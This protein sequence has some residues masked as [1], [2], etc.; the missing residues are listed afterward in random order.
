MNSFT[1]HYYLNEKWISPLRKIKNL[2]S[3][4][5]S[6][7]LNV[8]R[9]PV[10]QE[11]SERGYEIISEKISD[12]VEI[13]D[14]R[15][16]MASR[17]DLEDEEDS[18]ARRDFTKKYILKSA[19]NIINIFKGVLKGS[20][21]KLPDGYNLIDASVYETNL[22]GILVLIAVEMGNN[23]KYFVGS[24]GKGDKFFKN[25]FGMSI[26]TFSV[27]NRVNKKDNF[28]SRLDRSGKKD[29]KKD[30]DNINLSYIDRVEKV[31]DN[32]RDYKNENWFG[33]I[34]LKRE[35]YNKVI[36]RLKLLQKDPMSVSI[37]N[38]G[39]ILK[40]KLNSEESIYALPLSDSKGNEEFY[41]I[42]ETPEKKLINNLQ[43][44]IFKGFD[45]YLSD[46]TEFM[47]S[48]NISKLPSF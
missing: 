43:N 2:F 25:V 28:R 5:K 37:P 40:Y 36:N 18:R 46:K 39:M 29:N 20:N 14:R 30:V 38:I 34:D 10:F 32:I 6:Y 19:D 48:I 35:E 11:I 7:D 42:Y 9:L 31:I 22:N 17:L 44:T 41:I 1:E 26:Q 33:F 15:K 24:D 12:R 23:I 27:L 21:S 3:R 13:N 4:I 45:W 8:D 47:K 16:R